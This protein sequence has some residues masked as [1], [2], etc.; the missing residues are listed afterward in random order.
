MLE[1]I[2]YFHIDLAFKNP[3]QLY[4][5]GNNIFFCYT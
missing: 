2:S 3:Y 5:K 4:F 1:G